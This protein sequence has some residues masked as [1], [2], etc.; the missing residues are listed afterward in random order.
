M[1]ESEGQ[2]EHDEIVALDAQTLQLRHRFGLGLLND[3]NQ[4]VVVGE[5]SCTSVTP[6]TTACK[7]SLSPGSTAAQSW[8]SGGRLRAFALRTTA[9]TSSSEK[10]TATTTTTTTGTLCRDAGSLSCPCR[11]HPAGRHEPNRSHGQPCPVKVKGGVNANFSSV[12]PHGTRL[13]P[14]HNT[15]QE[16]A[17]GEA[18]GAVLDEGEDEWDLPEGCSVQSGA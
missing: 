2:P 9:S 16:M 15:N 17:E 10:T 14:L 8:V 1:S 12:T 13:I 11:A 3:A 4:L 5:T 6:T 7:S 18:L